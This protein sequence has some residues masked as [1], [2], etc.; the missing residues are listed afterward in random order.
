MIC[1]RFVA[2]LAA[3]T[4]IAAPAPAAIVYMSQS[5]TAA[6]TAQ[7]TDGPLSSV[8]RAAPDFGP[9]TLEADADVLDGSVT[10]SA[11]LTS[12]LTD[13][14]LVAEGTADADV[15]GSADADA[16]GT[17]T[18]DVSFRLTERMEYALFIEV[19]NGT[20]ELRGPDINLLGGFNESVNE[21]RVILGPGEY[22][23]VMS[24]VVVA[25]ASERSVG[26]SWTLRFVEIPTPGS[27]VLA[28][29]GGL[30]II[31]RGR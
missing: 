9:T 4:A 27:I 10:A 16:T 18:L 15:T 12:T 22:R 5:R 31:R 13:D 28:A 11:D 30:A 20:Y 26:G 23:V 6:A 29:I 3:A 1:S 8:V 25:D 24:T 21:E 2:A 17:S 19:V 7:V 14:A